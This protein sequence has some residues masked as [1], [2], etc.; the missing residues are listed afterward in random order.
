MGQDLA[1]ITTLY[2]PPYVSRYFSSSGE[3][4]ESFDD[5]YDNVRRWRGECRD[6]GNDDIFEWLKENTLADFYPPGEG[7]LFLGENDALCRIFI[8]TICPTYNDGEWYKGYSDQCKREDKVRRHQITIKSQ[9]K[10][11]KLPEELLLALEERY[12][13]L[14]EAP[15]LSREEHMS[16]PEKVA[17]A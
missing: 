17:A 16:F 12:Y 8:K 9:P 4:A 15:P 11:R 7:F 3:T 2:S 13:Y 10:S 6:V 5:K 1:R 14:G